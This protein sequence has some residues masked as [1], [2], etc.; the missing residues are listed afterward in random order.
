MT[1]C[2]LVTGATGFIGSHVVHQ[3]LEQGQKVRVLVRNPKKLA[4]VGLEKNP[5]LE[6]VQGD[7]LDPASLPPALQGVNQIHHIAGFISTLERD[8]EKLHQLNYDITKNLFTACQQ[9]KIQK[10]VYLASIFALGGASQVPVTEDATYNLDSLPIHYFKAK[11]KAELYAYECLT[12]GLPIVFA[13][14]CFCYGPGDVYNSS[15]EALLTFLQYPV[16]GYV[17][18]GLNAMDVRDAANGLILAMEKGEVGQRYILGGI[19]ISNQKLFEMLAH[20]CQKRPPR[21]KIPVQAGQ[22]VGYLAEKILS[23]PPIDFQ[24]A[25]ILGQYWYYDSTKARRELGFTSRPLE[26]SLRDAV[27][28]FCERGIAPWPSNMK[29]R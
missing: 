9:H 1:N 14:P 18:G 13:Y 26:E 19:N 17:E 27:T 20:I 28:W 2:T 25:T 24:A 10:I 7:L 6:V 8:K 15:S 23:D 22:I 29:P 21:L 12:Q 3:L 11:R 5:N 16:P 4:D